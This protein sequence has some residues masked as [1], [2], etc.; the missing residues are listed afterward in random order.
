MRFR[1]LSEASNPSG[2]GD[3]AVARES[4]DPLKLYLLLLF[5]ARPESDARGSQGGSRDD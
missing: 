4:V 5:N 2:Q 1:W 3:R